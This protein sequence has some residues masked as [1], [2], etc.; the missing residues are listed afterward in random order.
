M[1]RITDYRDEILD[2]C[3]T[4]PGV[5]CG[6]DVYSLLGPGD[7]DGCDVHPNAAGHL[8]MFRELAPAFDVAPY[9]PWEEV[10]SDRGESNG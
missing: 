9:F 7:F 6:P 1:D 2:V 8:A 10:A 3:S 4:T 5:V